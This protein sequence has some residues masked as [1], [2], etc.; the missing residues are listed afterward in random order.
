VKYSLIAIVLGCGSLLCTRAVPGQQPGPQSN[1]QY[2]GGFNA[3]TE[4]LFVHS[5]VEVEVQGLNGSLIV[6]NRLCVFA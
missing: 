6:G 1:G 5:S 4:N 2:N 3:G